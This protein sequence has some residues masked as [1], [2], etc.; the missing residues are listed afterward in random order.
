MK[1]T[2]TDPNLPG[3]GVANEDD[4]VSDDEEYDEDRLPVPKV[5]TQGKVT[6]EQDIVRYCLCFVIK[7]YRIVSS[8]LIVYSYARCT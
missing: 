4:P 3:Q 1:S 6:E 5:D 8:S 2:K 7:I